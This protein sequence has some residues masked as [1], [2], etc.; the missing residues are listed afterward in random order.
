MPKPRKLTP[1]QIKR[2]VIQ[3]LDEG[4]PWPTEL[5][6]STT[7]SRE[8]D[9]HDGTGRG[10][11][12]VMIGPDGDCYIA[13]DQSTPML[14]Y[15]NWAGGGKSLRTQ[16]ALTLLALAIRLD[17]KEEEEYKKRWQTP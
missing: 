4:V 8:H 11:L 5:S 10:I 12:S 7:Y 6:D 9:D 1:E 16:K 13:T 17:N 2:A 3:I 14:R 15:R